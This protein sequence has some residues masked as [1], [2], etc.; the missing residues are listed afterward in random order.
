ML[1]SGALDPLLGRTTR[2]SINAALHIHDH[3]IRLGTHGA[4]LC[5]MSPVS[6]MSV[7]THAKGPPSAAPPPAQRHASWAA[8]GAA[9]R[10]GHRRL[11]R[12]RHSSL[13]PAA[14]P[15][16]GECASA[17]AVRL[18]APEQEDP[19]YVEPVFVTEPELDSSSGEQASNSAMHA[20]S[21][22][23]GSQDGLLGSRD[24]GEMLGFALP[25]LGMVLAGASAPW[26]VSCALGRFEWPIMASSPCMLY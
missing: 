19:E 18:L 8:T 7:F 1:C 11:H 20:N 4:P 21:S 5:A 3:Q 22:S 16:S 26:P 12:R 6:T 2:P 24:L 23:G 25:A 15:E 10:Q 13:A 14:V 9:I 17:A